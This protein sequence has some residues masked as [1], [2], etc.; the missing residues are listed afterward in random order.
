MQN[1]NYISASEPAQLTF[2]AIEIAGL[3]VP[4]LFALMTIVLVILNPDP[5]ANAPA[6]SDL[7]AERLE[8]IQRR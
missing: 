4:V 6:K 3:V 1:V 7:A 8:Q 2:D 5:A